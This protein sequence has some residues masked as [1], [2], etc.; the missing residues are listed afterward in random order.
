MIGRWLRGILFASVV[1][2]AGALAGFLPGEALA[3][4]AA[5]QVCGDCH[6]AQMKIANS[7]HGVSGDS[8]TPFGSG[9]GCS[10]CH[11]NTAE[12]VKDNDKLP[13]N[14]LSVKTQS[15][16]AKSEV[17]LTCHQSGTR[18]H[19]QGSAHDR[20]DIACQ[21]CHNV[22]AAK[23]QVLV[24][25]TQA[26]VCFN[27]HKDVRSQIF[28]V[29]AHPI[30]QGL[31]GCASCHAPHGSNSE[32]AQLI[33][34]SVNE[35]CYTCH[36]AQR[37]PF[38]WEH[39]PVKEDCANCHN[40]HGSVNRPMLTARAPFLCQ[41]CHVA[42]FHPSTLRSGTALPNVALPNANGPPVAQPSLG[43]SGTAYLVGQSCANCHT[44][45]HGSNHPSGTVLT[46]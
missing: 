28:Q 19:W 45:V 20:N 36:P 15:P 42:T 1:S 40:P 5:D 10:A 43:N 23:D 11:G 30:R 26:G 6:E 18:I 39:P 4:V 27:C 21:S 46:R 35:T 17:C 9:K 37:G 44:K 31:M 33:R 41:Q 22:H 7:K 12:H 8:R 24:Q 38:L 13:T 14:L 3:Q 25:A 32:K 2:V 34:S 29:S 16:L